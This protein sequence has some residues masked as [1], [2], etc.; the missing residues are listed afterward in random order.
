MSSLDKQVGG[1]HYASQALQPIEYIL[2]N[3]IG[4]CE[5]N[6]I[7]YVTRYSLKGGVQDLEKAK[8]YIELL[9]EHVTSE[10]TESEKPSPRREEDFYAALAAECERRTAEANAAY[11]SY[12]QD[13]LNS[14]P[15]L[16]SDL[17]KDLSRRRWS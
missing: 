14:G 17:E 1:D 12:I 7:K 11:T 5:G 2:A 3:N 6:V 9:I 15:A 8:H 10:R 13:D 4:F 16:L